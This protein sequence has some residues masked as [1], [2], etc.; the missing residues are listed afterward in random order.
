MK[1]IILA[2]LLV[3]L[4][5]ASFAGGNKAD[6][7]LLSD[8]Q[9][10]L[11]SSAQVQWNATSNY[12]RATFSF[13]GKPVSAYYDLNDNALIGFGFRLSQSELPKEVTDAIQ[14]KY[15]D[16]SIVEGLLFIDQY[17]YSNY[18][19]QVHKGKSNLALKIANGRAFIFSKMLPD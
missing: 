17:G 15:S 12:N 1:K 18:F 11:K 13:N 16:W 6:K 19:A 14:K 8:L 4:S 9:T 3:A 10:T 7:K 2:T 5:I